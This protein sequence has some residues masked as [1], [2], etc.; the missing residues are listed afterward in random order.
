[1]IGFDLPD[2]RKGE[3][4]MEVFRPKA[5]AGSVILLPGRTD[6]KVAGG[7]RSRSW[8]AGLEKGVCGK[9]PGAICSAATNIACLLTGTIVL[10]ALF[11]IVALPLTKD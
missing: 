8:C 4:D 1:M 3:Y 10:T 9:K 6:V 2:I 5:T 7:E 11:F